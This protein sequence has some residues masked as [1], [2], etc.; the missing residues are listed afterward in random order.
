MKA[1]VLESNGVLKYKDVPDPEV[2]EDECLI[3]VK[4]AGICNSDIYRAFENG[5]YHYPLIMGHEFSGEIVKCGTGVHNLTQ[6]QDVAVF[7][8]LPC[9]RCEW[10]KKKRWI[11]CS[12]YDYYGSRRDGAF[13]ELISIKEWNLIALPEGCDPGL[14]A[15]TEPLAVSIHALKS[16]HENAEGRLLIIGAGFIGLSLA[17]LAERIKKFTE[18]W[19]LDRNEFKL[20]FAKSLGFSTIRSK[21]TGGGDRSFEKYFDV[22]VEACGAVNTYKE[23]ISFCNNQAQLIWVGNIQGGLTLS[24]GEV[25]SVLRKEIK[26]CGIW[27]SDYQ[28]GAPSDWTDTLDIISREN[29][30]KSLISHRVPLTEAI[31]LLN[32]MYHV[33]R[34]HLPHSYLKACIQIGWQ[35]NHH[36]TD[37]CL[38]LN[39][40]KIPLGS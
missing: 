33:K 32:D 25:S 27:N 29:W 13:A 19:V 6:G 15:I 21:D 36:K 17:K 1:I 26:I 35:R 24:K 37:L 30:I 34:H 5:A 3:K 12:A 10:C 28:P 38:S 11:N 8:L 20:D 39:T 18:I 23:S 22:V 2:Q 40:G 4:S 31:H 7:P 16:F 14:A 9:L